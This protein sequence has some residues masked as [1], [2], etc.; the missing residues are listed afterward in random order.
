M[1][2]VAAPA[3]V[4]RET[5]LKATVS[6]GDPNDILAFGNAGSSAGHFS[7]TIFG[8]VG[9]GPS[10]VLGG[11]FLFRGGMVPDTDVRAADTSYA[12]I[13]QMQATR[14]E[15]ADPFNPTST[16]RSEVVHDLWRM[17]NGGREVNRIDQQ[18]SLS[19][20]LSGLE[21]PMY[22][23]DVRGNNW[24]SQTVFTGS[25]LNDCYTAGLYYLGTDTTSVTY[26]IAIDGNGTP[27]TFKWQKNAGTWTTGVNIVAGATALS[28]GIYVHFNATTGHTIGDQWVITCTPIPLLRLRSI[29]GT[30][31]LVVSETGAT[32]FA[33]AIRSDTGF[34]VGGTPGVTGT[35]LDHDGNTVHVVGGIITSLT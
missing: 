29:D 33:Q 8:R 3:V 22:R 1:V 27:N 18:G 26:T 11:C 20:G 34:S 4:G 13:I 9:G 28:D 14:W 15:G 12:P 23:L 21:L 6:D 7:P 2:V 25:G 32:T 24:T 30:E 35:F 31:Q 10:S 17:T 19:I 16:G 5:I